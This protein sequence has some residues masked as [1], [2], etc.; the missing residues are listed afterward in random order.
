MVA[1]RSTSVDRL[2]PATS[3]ATRGTPIDGVGIE[4][5]FV[6]QM[7]LGEPHLEIEDPEE[8]DPQVAQLSQTVADLNNRELTYLNGLEKLITLIAELPPK[9]VFSSWQT[10]GVETSQREGTFDQELERTQAQGRQPMGPPPDVERPRKNERTYMTPPPSP[11]QCSQE[12]RPQDPVRGKG[13]TTQ[14]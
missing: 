3:H 8:T 2:T 5:T 9:E 13:P 6:P 10:P 4:T 11:P 1:T 7:S 14:P 12:T